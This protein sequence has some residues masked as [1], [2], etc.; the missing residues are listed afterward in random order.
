LGLGCGAILV[1][2]VVLAAS[3]WS[4]INARLT[5]NRLRTATSEE[6]RT[7]HA[8]RLIA[9][10]EPG[11]VLGLELMKTGDAETCQALLSALFEVG[12]GPEAA[13][14]LQT[15]C[16]PYFEFYSQC[17]APGQDALLEGLLRYIPRVEETERIRYREIVQ[18]GF[19]HPAPEARVKAIRLGMRPEMNLRAGM[20]PLLKDEANAV[21]RAAMLAI[22]PDSGGSPAVIGDEDLFAYLHDPDWEVRT[23]CEA[24]LSTR[25]LEP[26]VIACARRLTHPEASE[27]L[28]LLG[29]LKKS[30]EAIRDP[31]PWL[32]RL[33]RD[34]D[35]A[36]RAGA[37]RL[38]CEARLAFAPWLNRLAT[39]DPDA[40][41][42]QIARYHRQK[43][44]E[45]RL[46][47]GRIE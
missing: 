2:A 5:A 19:Q 28:Q 25:G 37:A 21:R 41:V 14:L 39:Q 3:N 35:P 29:E 26:E 34:P 42:R 22:G 9:L 27:R 36:V 32:E 40:T 24:A 11:R 31:G 33:S 23:L 13:A 47:G 4:S 45:I 16:R 38:A 18:S 6:A 17:G 44:E 7:Q 1:L 8:Q 12:E 15:R 43:A 10:G 46:T 20:V 30:S